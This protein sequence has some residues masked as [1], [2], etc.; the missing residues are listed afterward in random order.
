MRNEYDIAGP[1]GI[2][3][4]CKRM[5]IDQSLAYLEKW[6]HLSGMITMRS[7]EVKIGSLSINRRT[8]ALE[9]Q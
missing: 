3:T 2:T 1:P 9:K 5:V 4:Q 8:V 7:N 6:A